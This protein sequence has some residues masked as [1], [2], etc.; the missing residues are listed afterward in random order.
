MSDAEN[1]HA[2]NAVNRV[3]ATLDS[4]VRVTVSDGRL[5]EGQLQC[6][7]SDMNIV[8]ANATEYHDVQDGECHRLAEPDCP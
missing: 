1:G 5:V 7:D 6:L 3:K 2:A 4:V 8:L